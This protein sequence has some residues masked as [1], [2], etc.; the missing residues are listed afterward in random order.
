MATLDDALVMMRDGRG[1]SALVEAEKG[2]QAWLDR[3]DDDDPFTPDMGM[4]LAQHAEGLQRFRDADL[5]VP[6]AALAIRTFL[7]YPE[8]FGR[9]ATALARAGQIAADI[10]LASGRT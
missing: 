5:G 9:T 4:A 6:P 3:F 1:A 7:N 2:M 8:D 10:H